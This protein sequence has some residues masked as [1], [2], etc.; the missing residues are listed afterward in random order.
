M[1]NNVFS[2]IAAGLSIAST[3]TGWLVY[4][5]SFKYKMIILSSEVQRLRVNDIARIEK[6]ISDHVE[7]DL[8][9]RKRL[10]RSLRRI[11]RTLV[12][13]CMLSGIEFPNEQ[14]GG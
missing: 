5:V 2:Y 13:I 14:E 3:L 9:E 11:D 1:A 4:V 12:R 10:G 7:R 8:D 6:Q